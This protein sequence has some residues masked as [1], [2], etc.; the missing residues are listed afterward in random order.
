[1]ALLAAQHLEGGLSSS[2]VDVRR[3][4]TR[5]KLGLTKEIQAHLLDERC[6]A[7]TFSTCTT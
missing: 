7:R 1:M 4:I 6:E 3:S 5:P 2:S